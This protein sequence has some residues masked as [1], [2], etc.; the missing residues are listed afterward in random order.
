MLI[1]TSLLFYNIILNIFAIFILP[2]LSELPIYFGNSGNSYVSYA[3]DACYPSYP[4]NWVTL[5][6]CMQLPNSMY[7]KMRTDV[8]RKIIKKY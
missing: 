5:Q 7:P 6:K 2:K 3:S 8:S 4:I 1:F